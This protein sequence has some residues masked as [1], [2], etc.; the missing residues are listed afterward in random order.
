LFIPVYGYIASAWAHIAAYGAM[1]ITSFIFARNH[2]RVKY[3]M[4][5]LI[6]YFVLAIGM[7]IF[8][9]LYNYKSLVSELLINTIFIAGFIVYAQ[10]Q[11][12]LLTVFLKKSKK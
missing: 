2:Y 9:R 7:V 1:I 3:N 10:Y 8:S 6:P 12:K 5:E 11:D 4:K